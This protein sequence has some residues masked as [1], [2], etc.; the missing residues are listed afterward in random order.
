[1]AAVP[2]TPS[3]FSLLCIPQDVI[4]FGV[5]ADTS[6]N[7]DVVIRTPYPHLL[8]SLQLNIPLQPFQKAISVLCW[9]AA[10]LAWSGGS[11]IQRGGWRWILAALLMPSDFPFLFLL[12][13]SAVLARKDVDLGRFLFFTLNFSDSEE[14]LWLLFLLVYAYTIVSIDV[15]NY[16]V[17]LM[18]MVKIKCLWFY[19][20]L[21]KP[22]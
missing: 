8:V 10:G 5:K 15:D 1:M 9:F 21:L 17:I 12:Q 18:L 20:P 6:S 13:L 7:Q 16:K 4:A 22:P 3:P 19:V 11:Q 14:G 2:G